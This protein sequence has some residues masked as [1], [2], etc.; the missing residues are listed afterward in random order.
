MKAVPFGPMRVRSDEDAKLL[1]EEL[2]KPPAGVNGRGLKLQHI[3]LSIVPAREKPSKKPKVAF[4][5]FWGDWSGI[6]FYG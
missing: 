2:Q 4:H 1:F 5:L 3:T 6:S